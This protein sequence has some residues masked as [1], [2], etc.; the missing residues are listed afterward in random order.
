MQRNSVEL[1]GGIPIIQMSEDCHVLESLL[2]LIYPTDDWK[3]S[4]LQYIHF[5]FQA[6]DKYE[7]LDSFPQSLARILLNTAATHPSTAYSLACHYQMLKTAN[8]IAHMTLRQRFLADEFSKEDM[9]LLPAD[10]YNR[11]L[12]YHQQCSTLASEAMQH[13]WSMSDIPGATERWS[14]CAHTTREFGD[15][16]HIFRVKNWILTYLNKCENSLRE[17]PHGD[18]VMARNKILSM[19]IE[20]SGCWVCRGRVDQI[21]KFVQSVKEHIASV[22]DKVSM[23]Y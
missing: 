4:A 18:T 21:P 23:H 11:L 22:V 5:F 8:V 17:R 15:R 2:R 14:S 19:F 13:W 6:V 3:C 12:L 7:M 10:H 1:E 20:A 9:E 16:P